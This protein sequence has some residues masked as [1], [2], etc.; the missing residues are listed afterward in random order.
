[1]NIF[2]SGLVLIVFVLFVGLLAVGAR[3]MFSSFSSKNS[4]K[5]LLEDNPQKV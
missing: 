1:M 5:E 4:E 3:T 2:L